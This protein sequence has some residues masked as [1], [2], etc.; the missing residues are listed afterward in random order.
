MLGTIVTFEN[1]LDVE[2]E[3]RLAR[4]SV[5][6]NANWDMLGCASAPSRQRGADLPRDRG[7]F[8]PLVRGIVDPEA[9]TIETQRRGRNHG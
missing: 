5:S 8:L 9:R 2:I 6:F 7:S 3:N 1:N 4:A